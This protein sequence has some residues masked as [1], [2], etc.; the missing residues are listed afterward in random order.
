MDIERALVKTSMGYIHYRAAGRGAPVVLLHMN[1]QSSALYLE[2]MAVLALTVR[3]IAIDYPSHGMSD[4]ITVQPTI[5]DYARCVLEVVDALGLKT[6]SFLGE[7][8][9]AVVCIELAAAHPERVDKIVMVNCPWYPDN[10]TATRNHGVLKSGARPSDASGFPTTRTIEFMLEHDP[11]HAPMQPT[12]SWMDRINRAQLEAGRERWQV[13][14]AL[15][16]YDMPANVP[17][18]KRPALQL[19]G[20]HF[21]YVKD[22]PEFAVRIPGLRQH[23]IAGGRCCVAWEKADDIG[24]RTL[25][26]LR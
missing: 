5:A 3:A 22:H 2:L 26:F 4:H 12:Q 14:D 6:A 19:T 13:L 1:Q 25:E 17:R 20:E 7:S 18:V 11:A 8:G 24:K 15:H 9:G 23:V 16:Q 10:K 21:I